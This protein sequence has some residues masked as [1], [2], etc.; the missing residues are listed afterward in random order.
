MESA[1]VNA[2]AGL[3]LSSESL[4]LF[5][6]MGMNLKNQNTINKQLTQGLQEVRESV[7][8]LTA[9]SNNES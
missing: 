4:V 9:K 8:L 1:L 5:A 2:L 7:L 3:G 6:L